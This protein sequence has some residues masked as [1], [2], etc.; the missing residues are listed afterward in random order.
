VRSG[1][2]E[3]VETPGMRVLF[4]EEQTRTASSHGMGHHAHDARATQ[5]GVE[6]KKNDQP[7]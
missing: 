7:S 3:D 6:S 2:F 4:D 5:D 1:Q